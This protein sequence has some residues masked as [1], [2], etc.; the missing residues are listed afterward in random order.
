[1]WEKGHQSSFFFENKSDHCLSGNNVEHFLKNAYL[2]A[3]RYHNNGSQTSFRLLDFGR[4]FV[5]L[6]SDFLKV[7]S[8]IV[9]FF[10][11]L[12]VILNNKIY[13]GLS[14]KW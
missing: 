6:L 1:M 11:K 7:L 14:N 10:V 13:K 2:C 9:K 8:D 5:K 4:T 3:Y 12:L